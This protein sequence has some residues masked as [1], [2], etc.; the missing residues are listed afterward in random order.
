MKVLL[1][2]PFYLLKERKRLRQARLLPRWSEVPRWCRSVSEEI[3]HDTEIG[4]TANA[5]SERSQRR[6]ILPSR[7][8]SSNAI[9]IS[10]PSYCSAT[11]IGMNPCPSLKAW[12]AFPMT[13]PKAL[14]G[15]SAFIA[16]PL[17][18][19]VVRISPTSIGA[20]RASTLQ[21]HL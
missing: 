12:S 1:L 13:A 17:V 6:H 11:K 10:L 18:G 8:V 14:P 3:A 15:S 4:G 16:C 19:E 21:Y 7:I 20:E 2:E 5:R 9:E